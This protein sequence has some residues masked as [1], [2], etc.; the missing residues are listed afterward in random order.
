[1]PLVSFDLESVSGIYS[2]GRGKTAD[3]KG[4]VRRRAGLQAWPPAGLE[5]NAPQASENRHFC[6]GQHSGGVGPSLAS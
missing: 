5:R 6:D 2:T 1:M 3:P 4:A